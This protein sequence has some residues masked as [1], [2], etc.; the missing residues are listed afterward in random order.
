MVQIMN[1]IDRLPNGYKKIVDAY[2]S[3]MIQY[4]NKLNSICDIEN[5]R[6]DFRR[7]SDNCYCEMS[8]AGVTSIQANKIEF[9]L[10]FC[11]IMNIYQVE[12]KNILGIAADYKSLGVEIFLDTKTGKFKLSDKCVV[13]IEGTEDFV[14][15]YK[16]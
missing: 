3:D 10:T 8:K 9:M 7:L 16:W 15:N 5:V 6:I 4:L 11:V 14:D 2:K 12:N 1:K 13:F